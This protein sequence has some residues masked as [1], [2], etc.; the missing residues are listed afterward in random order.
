MPSN[1]CPK[2]TGFDSTK[3]GD[4]YGLTCGYWTNDPDDLDTHALSH[5]EDDCVFDLTDEQYEEDQRLRRTDA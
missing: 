1:D 4:R 2:A 5:R 3:V